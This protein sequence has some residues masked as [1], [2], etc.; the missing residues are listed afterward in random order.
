[1]EYINRQLLKYY[2]ALFVTALTGTIGSFV[3]TDPVAK[4]SYIFLALEIGIGIS[5]IRIRLWMKRRKERTIR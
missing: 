1:M 2:I 5:F 3:A 4:A